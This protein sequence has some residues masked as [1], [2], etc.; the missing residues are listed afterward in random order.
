LKAA[1]PGAD[2]EERDLALRAETTAVYLVVT[3]APHDSHGAAPAPYQINVHREAAPPDFEIEPNDLPAQATPIANRRSG[4]LSPQ[5]DVD[6]YALHLTDPSVLH[7]ALSPLDH[8]DTELAV[9]DLENGKDRVLVRV[10]EGGAKEAEVIPA[11]VLSPGDHL[12]RV[13]AALHQVGDKWVRDQANA[14]DVYTLTLALTPDEGNHERE[15]NDK[16]DQATPVKIGQTLTGYAYPAKDVDIY[17]LD[18]SAQPVGTGVVIRLNGALKVPLALELRGAPQGSKLGGLLN[19]SDL[20]KTGVT[21]EIR[22][23]LE[24]GVYQ[25]VVRPHPPS[26]APG[27]PLADPDNPYQLSVQSE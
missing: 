21:E 8:V 23:K 25:I 24:P 15:P 19:T 14:D 9:V 6:Y 3:G 5:G 12:V 4:Y 16:A 7:A 26:R 20:G 1:K 13:Q 11:L 27:Q 10:N 18:L 22:A 2:I 17:Q